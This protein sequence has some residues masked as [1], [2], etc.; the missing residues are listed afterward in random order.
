MYFNYC[1]PGNFFFFN[2]LIVDPCWGGRPGGGRGRSLK[3]F[4]IYLHYLPDIP[5]HIAMQWL[6]TRKY[7]K[8][9]Y[10]WHQQILKFLLLTSKDCKHFNWLLLR[11]TY[12]KHVY[13]WHQQMVKF[14]TVYCWYQQIVNIFSP[15]KQQMSWDNMNVW[16]R[17]Q[18]SKFSFL[19]HCWASVFG[20]D[21]IWCI[22]SR[23]AGWDLLTSLLKIETKHF[24]FC[25]IGVT[26]CIC[27]LG[28]SSGHYW[29]NITSRLKISKI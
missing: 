17:S 8:H 18:T 1:I 7:C 28:P 13:C 16:Q 21:R 29:L 24:Y 6:L 22:S 14:F 5:P 9:F 26:T 11:P 20:K 23:V 19:D 10:C 12:C 27:H 2:F 15:R 25:F 4:K 3:R